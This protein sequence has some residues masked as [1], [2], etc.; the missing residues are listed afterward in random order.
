ME[1]EQGVYPRYLK[2][3]GRGSVSGQ[4]DSFLRLCCGLRGFSDH[5]FGRKVGS[6]R[7]EEG[8]GAID[9]LCASSFWL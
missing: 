3:S 6:K 1:K 8:K 7:S 2:S 5:N 9:S 4:G